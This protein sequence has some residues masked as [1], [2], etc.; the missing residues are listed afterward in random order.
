MGCWRLLHPLKLDKIKLVSMPFFARCEEERSFLM[1]FAA[2]EI[3]S[4][5]HCLES[6]PAADGSLQFVLISKDA[7]N[8]EKCKILIYW[9]ASI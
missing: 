4:T 9:E 8:V 2:E 5:S 3:L 1:H 7:T 6:S